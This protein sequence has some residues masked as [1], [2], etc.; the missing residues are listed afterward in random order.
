MGASATAAIIMMKEKH[1]V[2]AFRAAGAI[3]AASAVEPAA[4]GVSERLAFSRLRQ[5]AVLR[6][7]ASGL[8]YL[9]EPTW[10]A[11]RRVRRRLV[12]AAALL[13]LAGMLALLVRRAGVGAV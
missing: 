6:E 12:L 9:D 1:I 2:A 4:L 8:F 3:S 11:L 7:V 13:A 5:R 10:E